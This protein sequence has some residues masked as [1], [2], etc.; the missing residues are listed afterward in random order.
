MRVPGFATR[1]LRLKGTA[2]VLAA[3]LWAGVAYASNPP[4]TRSV[5]IPVPQ[6]TGSV[7]PYVLVHAIPD[8]VIRVS[9]TRDHLS[10]FT[11]SDLVVNVDYRAIRQAGVQSVPLSVI[12]NDRDVALESP[13]SSITAEVDRLDSR[14]VNVTVDTNPHPPQGYVVVNAVTTPLAV[15]VIGPQHQLA[16][17]QAKVTVNLANQKTNFQADE[18]V[19]L[20]D[21]RTGQRLGN[22]GLSITVNGHPQ[23]TVL[24]TIEVAASLTSRASAVLPKVSGSV[25]AG[26][27]LAAESVSPATVVLN[28]PQDLLNTLDSVQTEAISLNGITGTLSFTVDLTPPAGVTANPTRVTVTIT[29]ASLS[30]P[31][32]SPTAA[33]TPAPTPSPTT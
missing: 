6:D 23:S 11:P 7:A 9:G 13:P 22:F 32:P 20:F 31:T 19:Q 21:S 10:A 3:V 33:A 15:T 5:T 30:Q 27:Y 14:S 16:G 8:L 2:A 24:V 29:V 1:N 28:G 4:D 26:H 12:N 17:V 25:A 18:T